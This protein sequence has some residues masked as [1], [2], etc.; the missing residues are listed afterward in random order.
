MSR[1]KI[2]KQL[3][4]QNPSLSQSDLEVVIDTGQGGTV[5]RWG[6]MVLRGGT[7]TITA[8]QPLEIIQYSYT[9]ST[10]KVY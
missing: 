9:G 8:T 5:N 10:S 4:I 7:D 6:S 1:P 3:K 2:I